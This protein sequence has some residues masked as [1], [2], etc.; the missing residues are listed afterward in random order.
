MTV[1]LSYTESHSNLSLVDPDSHHKVHI[2]SNNMNPP[3]QGHLAIQVT[4]VEN[5]AHL[6]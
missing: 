2:A 6:T 4:I 1:G 3:T 5:T